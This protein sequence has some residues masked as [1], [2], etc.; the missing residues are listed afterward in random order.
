MDL[1]NIINEKNIEYSTLYQLI[2]ISSHHGTSSSEGHYTATCLIDNKD[3][4]YYFNDKKFEKIEDDKELLEDEE[5]YILFYKKLNIKKKDNIDVE[6]IKTLEIKDELINDVNNNQEENEEEENEEEEDEE[7][8]EENNYNKN[9]RG[10][11]FRGRGGIPKNKRNKNNNAKKKYYVVKVSTYGVNPNIPTLQFIFNNLP[12][13]KKKFLNKNGKI[14]GFLNFKNYE[15]AVKIVKEFTEHTPV[16]NGCGV[17]L[18]L[19]NN[20]LN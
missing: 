12:N 2:C 8:E 3:T 5:P 9:K 11:V 13:C 20:S 15:D 19:K 14:H 6:K 10:N 16:Y 1:K 7:E 18:T 17:K 4:Y